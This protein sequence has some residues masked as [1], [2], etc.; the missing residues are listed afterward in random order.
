MYEFQ[1]IPTD[2]QTGEI[3]KNRANN[4][5]SFLLK[6]KQNDH[7]KIWLLIIIL[8]AT[9]IFAPLRTNILLLGTDYLPPREPLSRTDTIILVTIIPLKPY[10][11]MLSIPRD[12]WVDIPGFNENRINT[13]YY[14]AELAQKGS[15]PAKVIE[16]IILN[17][18]I[19]LK[20]YLKINMEGVIGIFD[21]LGGVEVDLPVSMGG[22]SAGLHSL[23]GTEALEFARER[24]SADD[25]SRMN[26][27]QILIIAFIT[28]LFSLRGWPRIP[29]VIYQISKSIDTN[30]PFWLMPRLGLAFLRSGTSG[31]DN[32]I[33]TR[34][35]VNP[36]TTNE[37]AQV[38][39]PNWDLINPV[40]F[41]MF[42]Q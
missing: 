22:L 1:P 39:S 28:K 41:E 30:I 31:I 35:M 5:Y 2:L 42:R 17:F 7:I 37:G 12:L 29:L 36:Y 19:S 18:G 23:N 6:R 8:F 24:Y 14:F 40:I 33:I 13:A 11:G 38:L 3:S 15:G 16:T 34:E 27:G 4:N 25:F 32:R 20:Y 10:I 9:Y 26:Q 21:A